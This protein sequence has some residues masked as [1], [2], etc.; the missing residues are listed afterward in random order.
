MY[1]RRREK[2]CTQS[3]GLITSYLTT[4]I[5]AE[6]EEFQSIKMRTRTARGNS[7]NKQL[8]AFLTRAEQRSVNEGKFLKTNEKFRQQT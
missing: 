1:R 4:L 7:G 5:L 3:I 2:A 8:C 6:I